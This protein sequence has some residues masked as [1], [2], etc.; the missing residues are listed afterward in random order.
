MTAASLRHQAKS[1]ELLAAL[2]I[3]GAAASAGALVTH[4]L[5]TGARETQQTQRASETAGK[6]A[7]LI[8]HEFSVMGHIFHV[9]ESARDSEDGSIRF[10]YSAPPRANI[11]EHTHRVQE[12]SFEVISGKLGMR[13]GG[14]ELILGPGQRAIGPPKVPHAWWNPNSEE[15]V[16]FVPAVRPGLDLETMFETLLGLMREGKTIGPIPKNPLQAAVLVQEIASWV[17]L[18]PVEKALLA[19]VRALAFVGEILGYRARYPEYSGP[20]GTGTA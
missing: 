4:R 6:P 12:E 9:I 17:V 2:G 18:T 14:Q 20:D 7:P 8:G 16:R 3:A 1:K 11:P 19:P 10:D 15:R 5:R 13:V